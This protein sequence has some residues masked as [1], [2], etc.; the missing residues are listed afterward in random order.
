MKA[1][2]RVVRKIRYNN[3]KE[4]SDVLDA[5]NWSVRAFLYHAAGMLMEGSEGCEIEPDGR[6]AAIEYIFDAV[7]ALDGKAPWV[8]E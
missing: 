1:N 4:Q 2:Q 8:T 5:T 7:D 3:Q 6:W